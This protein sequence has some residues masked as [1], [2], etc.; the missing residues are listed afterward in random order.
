MIA[1][2]DRA[3]ELAQQIQKD[4]ISKQTNMFDLFGTDEKG[5]VKE[6]MLPELPEWSDEELLSSEKEALGF[7][8][9]KHPLSRFDEYLAKYTSTDTFT[10]QNQTNDTEVSIGGIPNKLRE[11]TTRKGDRMCFL[12]LEDLKGVIEVVIFSDLYKNCAELLKSDQPLL[13]AGKVDTY[14]DTLKILAS[15]IT[16]LSEADKVSSPNIH[17]TLN[18]SETNKTQLQQLRKLCLTYPG[19]SHAFLHLVAPQKSETIISLGNSYKVDPSPQFANE[20][21]RLFGNT[22]QLT[23]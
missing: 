18:I 1:V 15:Q 19:D 14:G 2:L 22:A 16:P 20:I 21:K 3:I 11:I 10:V 12:T 9:S 23:K 17:F 6:E 13:V 5:T 8:I 7:Y 4:R